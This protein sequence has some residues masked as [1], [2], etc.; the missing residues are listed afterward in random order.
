M[1]RSCL[2]TLAITRHNDTCTRVTHCHYQA[3]LPPPYPYSQRTDLLMEGIVRLMHEVMASHQSI[4]RVD[5]VA[6]KHLRF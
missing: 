4:L 2:E 6:S 1:S 5:Q 3:S